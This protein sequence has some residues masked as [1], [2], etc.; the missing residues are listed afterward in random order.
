VAC[1]KRLRFSFSERA[2][3]PTAVLD[4]DATICSLTA[5]N[6]ERRHVTDQGNERGGIFPGLLGE[7]SRCLH[8]PPASSAAG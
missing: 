8:C 5:L 1:T 2:A 6:L 7:M 3:A 4:L